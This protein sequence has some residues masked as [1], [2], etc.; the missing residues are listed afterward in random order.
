[1]SVPVQEPLFEA[2][3]RRGV[4]PDTSLLASVELHPAVAAWFRERFPDG[5]TPAHRSVAVDRARACACGTPVGS[6][7]PA[8]DLGRKLGPARDAQLG[9][10]V[11]QVD[12][13]GSAGDEHA[14]AD[15]R[16]RHPGCDMTHDIELRRREALPPDGWALPLPASAARVGDCLFDAQRRAGIERRQVRVLAQR[17]AHGI[18]HAAPEPGLLRDPHRSQPSP[19]PRGGTEEPPIQP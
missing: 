18:R 2:P 4:E 5:P 3:A 12:L 15:L 7:L 10:D 14:L 11:R 6:G 8:D 19:S 13:H 9:E 16:V 1:M 17:V